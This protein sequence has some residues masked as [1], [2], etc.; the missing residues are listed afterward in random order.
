M[1]LLIWWFA[2]VENTGTS[3]TDV[4]TTDEA[5][6]LLNQTQAVSLLNASQVNVTLQLCCATNI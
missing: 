2:P 6:Y 1:D 3:T 5:V 4:Q